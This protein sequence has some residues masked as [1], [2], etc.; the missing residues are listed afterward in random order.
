MQVTIKKRGKSLEKL[1]KNV[2]RLNGQ[3]V[4]VG[5]FQEQGIHYSG[6]SYPELLQYWFVGV[7]VQGFAGRLRQ[8]V[9]SQF[10]HDYFNSDKISKDPRITEAINDWKREAL[11]RDNA[12][13]MLDKVGRVLMTEYQQKFNVKQG[14]HMNGTA[15]P[16]YETGE[17]ASSTAY[18]TSKEGIVKEK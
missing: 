9:R 10:I 12:K 3:S 17:L 2:K 1:I 18:K 8:D 14:P 11:H 7:E 6:M 15:T 4:Q 5:H 13:T 16:L